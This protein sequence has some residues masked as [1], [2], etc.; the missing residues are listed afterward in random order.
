MYKSN[1]VKCAL[2]LLGGEGKEKQKEL[3]DF[4]NW[5]SDSESLR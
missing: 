2:A 5:Q 4:N 1:A 3:C